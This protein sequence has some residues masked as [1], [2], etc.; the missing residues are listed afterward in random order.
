MLLLEFDCHYSLV[1]RKLEAR[2][3]YTKKHPLEQYMYFLAKM[4][5]VVGRVLR[6]RRN[7]H[8]QQNASFDRLL[9]RAG[10]RHLG[11]G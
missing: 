1:C 11:K 5:N 7:T 10:L 2:G 9:S 8:W 4:Y 6:M 3:I